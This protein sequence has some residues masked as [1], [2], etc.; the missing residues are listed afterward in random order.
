MLS[1][2]VLLSAALFCVG[3]YGVLTRRNAIA[4]LLAI[5]L[6]ANAANINFVAFSRAHGASFGQVFALFALA[7]TVAEVVVGIA[8]VI[9]LYR[10]HADVRVDV[11]SDLKH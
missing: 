10:S 11:A 2:Y 9:L 1:F 5:E 4:V 3:L 6:M 7:I 8:I